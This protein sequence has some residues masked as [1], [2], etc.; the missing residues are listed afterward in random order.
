MAKLSPKCMVSH[1]TTA[2]AAKVAGHMSE[3]QQKQWLEAH[4]QR[5][6]KKVSK[7]GVLLDV[8]INSMLSGLGT[9]LVN[10]ISIL[11]QQT[12]KNTNETIG[13]ALDKIGLTK[14]GREWRQVKAMWDG[15]L[16][17]FGQ[18]AL[19]F[20]EGFLRGSSLDQDVTRRMLNM[21]KKQF[22]E[23]LKEK[24]G[25]SNPDLMTDKQM[26]DVLN[27]MQDYMHNSIGRT[28]VGGTFIE[29]AV[30]FP[31][32]LIVGIDEFGKERYRRQ[33][34]NQLASRFA[35]EDEKN[36]FGVYEELYKSYKKELFPDKGFTTKWDDR[37]K[38]FIAAR[39]KQRFLAGKTKQTEAE[40]KEEALKE[41]TLAVDLLRNDALFNAFQQRLEGLPKVAQELRHKYP[42]FAL[43]TPFIKTPWNIIKEGYNYIPIIPTIQIKKLGREGLG[44][45]VLDLR[46]KVIPLHG[47]SERMTYSELLPRQVIGMSM[48]AMVGSMFQD[49]N[50]TGSIPRSSTERQRWQDAGIKPYSILIGDTWVEYGR[51][52]PLATPLAMASDLFTFTKEYADDDDINTEEAQELTMNLLYALKSNLTSKSFIEGFHTLTEAMIDPNKNSLAVFGETL[53]R[54]MTPAI[55]ANMAKASDEYERQTE[56]V[57]ER[58][59][60]RIPIL[61]QQLP[62]KFGVYGDAKET[63]MTKAIFNIGFTS[64]SG[65]TPLQNHLMD[66]EWDKGGIVN[67]FKG[68]KLSSEQLSELRQLNAESLTP[69]LNTI[70]SNPNYQQLPKGVQKRYLDKIVRKHRSSIG[71]QFAARLRTNDPVFAMKWLSAYYRKYGLEDAMPAHLKD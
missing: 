59:Q 69:A 30:R 16:E 14:G 32:K 67:S 21:D 43:F 23:F 57:M 5:S 54:P 13:F 9:P 46:T 31:T 58:L 64:D 34:M 41:G 29:G 12:L 20:R 10:V 25:I 65:L 38:T 50:L 35:S 71:K 63:D 42:A 17:G 33:G 62:K 61:R 4:L 28:R 56:G 53:F 40:M 24:M 60:A 18:D 45:T 70:T 68:V 19:F 36:G 26:S 22:H 47:P 27:D 7:F 11:V 52:E 39:R 51:I 3:P 1:D 2:L 44:E 15:A 8:M 48:F 66:I 55:L 49:E 6:D 37:T